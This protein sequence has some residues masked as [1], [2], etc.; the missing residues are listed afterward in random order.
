MLKETPLLCMELHPNGR[1]RIPVTIWRRGTEQTLAVDTFDVCNAAARQKFVNALP[2][3]VR[4]DAAR[5]LEQVAVELLQR[6]S[7]RQDSPAP[8]PQP[9]LDALRAEAARVLESPDVL[10]LVDAYVRAT[11]FA[12]DTHA[13]RLVYLALTSRL[14]ERPTNLFLAGPSAGGKNYTVRV[15]CPLFPA[16]AYYAIAGMSPLAV[17]YSPESF[18]HRVLIVAE[19]SA[20]HED[21]IGASLLR[22]LA[23]DAELKYDTVIDGESVR[24][25]KA[26]PT[27]LITTGTKR[28]EPELATRLWTVPVP[29]TPAHTRAVL[30]ATAAEAAAPGAVRGPDTAA[31]VAAQ[32]WLATAELPAVVVPFADV[33][34]DLVPVHEVRMRRDFTQLLTLV[35]AHALLHQ[36]HRPRDAEGRITATIEDYAAVHEIVGPVFTASLSAGLTPEVREAVGVVA[37]LTASGTTVTVTEIARQLT[38]SPSATWRRVRGALEGH[39]LVNEETRPRQP[40]KL[41]VGEPMPD[42]PG[43]PD[44]REL[45]QTR[46]RTTQPVPDAALPRLLD[47]LPGGGG[48]AQSGREE[49]GPG[50]ETD[51]PPPEA[52][53]DDPDDVARHAMQAGA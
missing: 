41:K 27:G 7:A 30:H 16:E 39:W 9:S 15:V 53:S 35:R 25:Q 3:D 19:A 36:H 13:P 28:L 38:L 52:P 18:A 43:L 34:A 24:L 14:L 1:A 17:M 12:G 47:G 46:K 33:L 31:F 10:A 29:D 20:F 51:V 5:T 40:A 32:R 45:V 49:G 26:G 11:G 37:S 23:W 2:E 44:P 50:L 42:V 48:G 6:Q 21:G 22:G 8:A 4:D